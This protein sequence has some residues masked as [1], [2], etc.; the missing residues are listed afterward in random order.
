[1]GFSDVEDDIPKNAAIFENE[2]D[3]VPG[4]TRVNIDY[5]QVL[6]ANEMLGRRDWVFKKWGQP[7]RGEWS[8]VIDAGFNGA[9]F[10]F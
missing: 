3:E 2:N 6:L 7:N 1:M 4:E 10:V 5:R 9:L 8:C